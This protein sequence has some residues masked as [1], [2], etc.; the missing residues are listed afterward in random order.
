MIVP[1][2]AERTP[3]LLRRVFTMLFSVIYSVDLPQGISIKPYTPPQVGRLW[4]RTEGKEQYDYS[5]LVD[6]HY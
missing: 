6:Q 5:Y 2:W 4:T 3:P 1:S